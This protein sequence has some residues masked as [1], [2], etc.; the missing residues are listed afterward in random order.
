LMSLSV[1]TQ[2]GRYYPWKNPITGTSEKF[3]SVTT[4]IG[5]GI[6]KPGL[7][8][9]QKRRVAEIAAENREHLVTLDYTA[10]RQWILDKAAVSNDGAAVL[11]SSVHN[12][13][14]DLV[15]GHNG[16]RLPDHIE[17]TF[18][19]SFDRFRNKYKPEY[20]ETEATVFSRQ[21]GYAGKLDFIA[22]IEGKTYL[23]DYKTGKSV[24]PESALQVAAYRH[25]DF[26]GRPDGTEDPLPV[27]DGG[28]ILHLRPTGF[29]V[30]EVDTGPETF[31]TFLSA[32]DIF[33]WL[34]IDSQGV[35]G[36]EW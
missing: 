16:G 11:G 33:R 18:L 7:N 21:H 30:H 10:A 36:R 28:V 32:L 34:N 6:P 3:V 23:G 13:L 15:S 29:K 1:D 4:I 31:D 5:Q 24:W 12:M 19:K 14:D 25:A 17:E 8:I 2:F 27:C 20:I 22:I 9:W 35:I 26:I